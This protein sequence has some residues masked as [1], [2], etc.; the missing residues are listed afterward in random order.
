MRFKKAIILVMATML[1]M[2]VPMIANAQQSGGMQA[3]EGQT[4]EKDQEDKV[5]AVVNG[6][7]IMVSEVDQFAGT[8]Q[9]VMSLYQ[10]NQQ[11]AQLLLQSEPGQELLK[12]F[13]KR[14]L[15]E[16]INQRLLEQ[17]AEDR[18]I[19]VS[20]QEKDEM[21]EQHLDQI[22][23][24]NDMSE[25]D[26]K[27]ALKQQGIESMDQYK[28]MFMEQSLGDAKINKLREEVAGDISVEESA[29]RDYYENNPGEFEQ[30][31]Q[32]DVSH[33]LLEDEETAEEVLNELNAGGDFAELAKEYSTGPSAEEGG[34]LGSINQ[35]SQISSEFKDA[36]FDLE[37]GEVSQ[38]VETE[39]GYHLIKVNEKTEAGKASFEEAKGQIEEKL[40]Q[41]EKQEDWNSFVEELR[42]EA[43]V[44]KKLD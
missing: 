27:Q 42:E 32:L 35:D 3:P 37:K 26:L 15:D 40:V 30:D 41:E 13:Q 19:E 25:E 5:A 2:T 1:V 33:I 24:Q 21:F 14:K 44:D 12:E 4:Q 7:E 20:Q 11:F 36:A 23:Q 29:L 6:E 9:L 43:D 16:L 18:N 31:E 38:P 10:S 8:Q 39:H 22:K 34:N 17:E 28:E